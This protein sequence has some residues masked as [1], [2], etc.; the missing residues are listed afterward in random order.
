M[1]KKFSKLF[2]FDLDGTL[3][4]DN[5]NGERVIP[6]S[7]LQTVF[8]LS[9][10]AHVTVAT[11]RRVRSSIPVLGQLP[12]IQLGVFHNGLIVRKQDGEIAVRR[13]IFADEVVEVAAV[14][15]ELG[16]APILVL[17]GQKQGIDFAFE[18]VP[19]F[20]DKHSQYAFQ[21]SKDQ[22]LMV[23]QLDELVEEFSEHLLEVACIGDFYHLL[24]LQKK[25]DERLPERLR[26]VLVRNCG[27]E[28][29]SILEVFDRTAS[30]RSGLEYIKEI[31]QVE[32]VI[33]AGDDEND[34]EMLEWANIGVSMKH[35]LPHIQK[36]AKFIVDGP[37]GLEEY[38][39]E[40]W[41][42]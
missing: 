11:G 3:V 25:L 14:L 37:Q 22:S 8:E 34:I 39:R 5:E 30:K 41:L 10:I 1:E 18:R 4:H 35:A 26:S 33:A 2:A 6:A 42:A 28:G 9:K 12:P 13:K 31:L 29:R 21:R 16:Q 7:L 15:R 23:D 19:T 36:K 27:Y 24:Q 40:T 20:R 32:E 17:D 38:L